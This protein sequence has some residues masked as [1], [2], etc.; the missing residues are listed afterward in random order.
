M[1]R[2][3]M[4]TPAEHFRNS[5]EKKRASDLENDCKLCREW[6]W[7]WEENG[8][9]GGPSGF[10]TGAGDKNLNSRDIGS[11]TAVEDLT[12]WKLNQK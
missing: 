7:W 6:R 12:H 1:G 8:G 5:A 9:C 4:P 10:H 2:T 3:D 11:G